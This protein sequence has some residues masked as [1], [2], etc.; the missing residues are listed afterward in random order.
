M[1]VYSKSFTPSNSHI[2]LAFLPPY[3]PD[4]GPIEYLWARLKRHALANYCP[5]NLDK[6]HS[7]AQ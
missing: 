1:T 5:A 4:L 7:S 2:Q 6:L 3:A